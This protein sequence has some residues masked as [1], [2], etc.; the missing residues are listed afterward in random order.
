MLQFELLDET[1]DLNLANSYHLSIQADLDGFSF[2]VLNPSKG[3]Y[4]V[5]KQYSFRDLQSEDDLYLQIQKVLKEDPLLQKSYASVFCLY[6]DPR[7]TLLPAALFD[8]DLLKSYFEFNHPLGDLDELHYNHLKNPDAYLIFPMYHEIASLYLQK[9]VNASFYHPVSALTDEVLGS[10]IGQSVNIH[11]Y[12]K[13]FD[14]IVNED[15][16]LKLHNNFSYRSEEDMLYFILFVFDKLELDQENTPVYLSGNIDKFSDS[17]SFLRPY[18]KN[19]NFRKFPAGFQ[20][21]PAFDR[22]QEHI[23]LTVFKIYHCG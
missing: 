15:K 2:S 5:L 10:A 6:P 19:L 9:W 16:H 20:Y 7:S 11:L 17:A 1:F 21:S 12:G 14:I 3:K 22:I 23:Y 4:I 8:R 18:F 13:H